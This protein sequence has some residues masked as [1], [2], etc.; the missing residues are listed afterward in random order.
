MNGPTGQADENY[1]GQAINF[2]PKKFGISNCELVNWPKLYDGYVD[3]IITDNEFIDKILVKGNYPAT[4]DPSYFVGK[5]LDDI[6]SVVNGI[7]YIKKAVHITIRTGRG[8]PVQ[9][10]IN[11]HRQ[12]GMTIFVHHQC[13][14]L[15]LFA[16]RY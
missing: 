11:S 9:C 2:V 8:V 4:M 5:S 7:S 14:I 16:Q 12:I 15:R 13:A 10:I 3:T 6:Q 1:S